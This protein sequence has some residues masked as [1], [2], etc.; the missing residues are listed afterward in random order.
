[1]RYNKATRVANRKNQI[2][3][4]LRSKA[5]TLVTKA[6]RLM[7]DEDFESAEGVVKQAVIAL[8]KAANKGALH[9]KNAARRKS[10]LI[11]QLHSGNSTD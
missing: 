2:K 11:R 4:P 1:M 10:R 5:R 6:R 7:T 3:G 8:D 9:R